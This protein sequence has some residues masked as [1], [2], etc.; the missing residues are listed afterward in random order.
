MLLAKAVKSDARVVSEAKSLI[1]NGYK[2]TAVV[3]DREGI[4]K[5]REVYEGIKIERVRLK[6]PSSNLL[7]LMLHLVLF[8]IITF[9]RLL[10]KNF[11]IVH[12][13]DF[14]TLI[15]GLFA[16]KLK[17]KKVVYDAH[18]IYSLMVQPRLPKKIVEILS[19]VE[20][21]LVKKVDAFI[22]VS[23]I[24]ADFFREVRDRVNISVIMNCKDPSDFEMSK[25]KITEFKVRFGIENHFVILYDGWLIPDSGL[26]ELFCAVENLN[27]QIDDIMAVICGDGCAEEKFKKMVKEKNIEKYVKFVG[28]IQSKD[29]PLFVKACDIMYLVYKSTNKYAFIATP[30]RLFEAIIAGKPIIASNFGELGR[31]LRKLGCGVLVN[32]VNPSNISYAMLDIIRNKHRYKEL[33]RHSKRASQTYNWKIMEERLVNLYKRLHTT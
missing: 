9:F 15:A 11:D 6:T 28:R 26:E 4:S 27:G 2:V 12:C 31:I 13:H 19:A 17:G 18:E 24:V 16:G 20:F 22:A 33:C 1:K 3:W 7:N 14:D 5:K 21:L 8:N 23:E 32:P 10:S 30:M 25:E 29:I